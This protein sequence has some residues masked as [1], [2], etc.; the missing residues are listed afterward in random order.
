MLNFLGAGPDALSIIVKVQ[1]NTAVV[2]LALGDQIDRLSIQEIRA[3]GGDD[4][5]G[6]IGVLES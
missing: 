4:Q 1:S 3:A 5:V 2:V 6:A